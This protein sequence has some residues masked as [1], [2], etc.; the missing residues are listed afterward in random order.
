MG[1]SVYSI[2]SV[3][4]LLLIYLTSNVEL[5]QLLWNGSLASLSCFLMGNAMYNLNDYFDKDYDEANNRD[6]PLLK[7]NIEPRYLVRTIFMLIA[8]SLTLLALVNI[9]ALAVG[10]I[11]L[12]LGTFYSLPPLRLKRRA[13][14]K[15]LTI[16]SI[17]MISTLIGLFALGKNHPLIIFMSISIGVFV[18]T[19]YHTHD[20][21]DMKGDKKE[22]CGTLPLIV[23]KKPTIMLGAIGYGLMI[24]LTLTG[25]LHFGLNYIIPAIAVLVSILNL[26]KLAGIW[27][28][29]GSDTAYEEVRTRN[30][31]A[32]IIFILMFPIGAL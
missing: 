24:I 28:P 16:S 29:N 25:T 7:K 20:I 8:V 30:R 15:P 21:R 3:A 13:W 27:P 17:I 18:S 19:I 5:I 2:C 9:G 11:C 22:G 6:K 26:K 12:I 1:S 14:G 31:M 32:I 10:V 4:G 23:G